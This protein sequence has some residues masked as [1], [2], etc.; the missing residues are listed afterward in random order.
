MIMGNFFFHVIFKFFFKVFTTGYF[1]NKKP[2][3]LPGAKD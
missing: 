3:N 1:K 2:K